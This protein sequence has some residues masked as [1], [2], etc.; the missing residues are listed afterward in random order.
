MQL[1]PDFCRLMQKGLTYL[2]TLKDQ[3]CSGSVT[4]NR[5]EF[6]LQY[7]ETLL[8]IITQRQ[9]QD[10]VSD[11]VLQLQQILERRSLELR[12]LQE[13]QRKV[14]NLVCMCE[15]FPHGELKGC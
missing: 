10:G 6:T 5:L 9:Q 7:R 11:E 3:L 8:E 2:D 15:I 13:S 14:A 1:S 12:A 4:V